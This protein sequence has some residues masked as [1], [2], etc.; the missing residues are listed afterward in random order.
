MGKPFIIPFNCTLSTFRPF[1]YAFQPLSKV[2]ANTNIEP[3]D[4]AFNSADS[5]VAL[6]LSYSS[7]TGWLLLLLLLLLLL[8]IFIIVVSAAAVLSVLGLVA[9]SSLMLFNITG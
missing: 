6:S 9:S 5:L 4:D 3:E 2:S 1:M 8:P 7:W